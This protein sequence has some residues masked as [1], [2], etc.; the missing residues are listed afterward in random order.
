MRRSRVVFKAGAE[1]ESRKAG[2]FLPTVLFVAERRERCGSQEIG[3]A[4]V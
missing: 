4:H 2:R 3:R 1:P